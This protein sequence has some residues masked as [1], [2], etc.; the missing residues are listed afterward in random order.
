MEVI[1]LLN[2]KNNNMSLKKRFLFSCIPTII[3]ALMIVHIVRP[4]GI[5][6]IGHFI[7]LNVTLII[8]NILLYNEME[9][10]GLS[11]D[12]R[13]LYSLLL[14][15]VLPFHYFVVWWVLKDR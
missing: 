8:Q 4:E 14:F 7:V 6:G 3:M 10:S 11:K 2:S 12:L 15:S 5:F 9:K 1:P 13:V